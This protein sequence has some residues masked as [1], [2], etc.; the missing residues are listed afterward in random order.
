MVIMLAAGLLL[1]FSGIGSADD[2]TYENIVI[3][4]IDP[5]RQ[6]EVKFSVDVTGEDI[7][8]VWIS[9]EECA[10]TPDYFCHPVSLNISMS[11]VDGTWEATATLEWDDTE[12]G[13]A[14]LAIKSNGT[15]Y[16]FGGDFT[17][18]TNFTV[19]PGDDGT[20]GN[21]GNGDNGGNDGNGEDTP[22]F[23]LIILVISVIVALFVFKRKIMK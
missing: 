3:D 8:E 10:L 6:S 9:I 14:W 21:G 19:V 16:D 5:T 18:H 13:H 20:N 11:K 17:K 22:G 12:E 15:W 4:P 2:P 23:E 1:S 7:E